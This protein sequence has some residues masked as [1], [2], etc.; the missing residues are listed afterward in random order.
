MTSYLG[1]NNGFQEFF[2]NIWSIIFCEW[3]E[4]CILLNKN[5]IK[6]KSK[7]Y[8]IYSLKCISLL[9]I[10]LFDTILTNRI[11]NTFSNNRL[12]G[13]FFY[14]FYY[15]HAIYNW[16][17]FDTYFHINANIFMSTGENN[18]HAKKKVLIH[19]SNKF[20]NFLNLPYLK[21]VHIAILI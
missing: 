12:I 8:I 20:W 18:I 5:D 17:E 1:K 15:P 11:S 9:R 3:I 13:T 7:Q 21:V 10:H 14:N 4:K 16:N 2:T 19:Y 6:I